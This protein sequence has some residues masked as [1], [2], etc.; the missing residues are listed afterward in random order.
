[1]PVLKP[2]VV[3][4]TPLEHALGSTPA[5]IKTIIPF[6]FFFLNFYTHKQS[7]PLKPD[8]STAVLPL[9]S[10]NCSKPA[11]SEIETSCIA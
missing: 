8:V 1:M 9:L 2:S 10:Q 4:A 7:L 6:S 3:A 5:A 11:A